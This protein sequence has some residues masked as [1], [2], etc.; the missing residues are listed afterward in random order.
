MSTVITYTFAVGLP[1]C[2]IQIYLLFY[3]ELFFTWGFSMDHYSLSHFK[4][5]FSRVSLPELRFISP[6]RCFQWWPSSFEQ[7]SRSDMVHPVT[8]GPIRWRQVYMLRSC[9]CIDSFILLCD[10]CQT[11]MLV[12]LGWSWWT[13]LTSVRMLELVL[14]LIKG[15]DVKTV[16]HAMLV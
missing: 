3:S 14:R 8:G 11:P 5:L 16:A 2:I 10:V 7:S 4:A 1:W 12:L 6:L 13:M 9:I 15:L